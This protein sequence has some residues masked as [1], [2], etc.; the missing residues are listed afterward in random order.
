MLQNVEDY[1]QRMVDERNEEFV[2]NLNKKGFSFKDICELADV[3]LDF[4]EKVLSK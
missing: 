1:A 4:V 2:L 3:S